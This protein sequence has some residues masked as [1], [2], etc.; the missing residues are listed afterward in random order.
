MWKMTQLRICLLYTGPLFLD[1]VIF[2][3][4]VDCKNNGVL[5]GSG[6]ILNNLLKYNFWCLINMFSIK[7]LLII[8]VVKENLSLLFKISTHSSTNYVPLTPSKS[9]VD[10]KR[11]PRLLSWKQFFFPTSREKTQHSL[12]TSSTQQIFSRQRSCLFQNLSLF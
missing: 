12:K 1:G 4:E 10:I 9:V 6:N 11:F 2:S 8:K 7:V 3:F 5:I